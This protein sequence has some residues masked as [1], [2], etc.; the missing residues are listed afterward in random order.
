MYISLT[1]LQEQINLKFDS[2]TVSDHFR[3]ERENWNGMLRHSLGGAVIC[4]SLQHLIYPA[5]NL[6]LYLFVNKKGEKPRQAD[7]QSIKFKEGE[8]NCCNQN[9]NMA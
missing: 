9:N 1:L 5:L 8:I 2:R 4:I 7:K 6:M 3:K